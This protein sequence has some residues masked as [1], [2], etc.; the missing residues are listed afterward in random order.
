MGS[1]QLSSQACPRVSGKAMPLGALVQAQGG[2][3]GSAAAWGAAPVQGGASGEMRYDRAHGQGQPGPPR[4]A[5]SHPRLPAHRRAPGLIQLS[6]RS[7][8]FWAAGPGQ[9]L[10]PLHRPGWGPGKGGS[11]RGNHCL[12]GRT[13]GRQ[14]GAA[15]ARA[16]ITCRPPPLIPGVGGNGP[17]QPHAVQR[18]PWTPCAPVAPCRPVLQRR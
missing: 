2:V 13:P 8:A 3:G 12:W 10:L 15:K 7:S 16:P 6:E 14:L 17:P 18:R 9:P 11:L 4:A 1:P 5:G